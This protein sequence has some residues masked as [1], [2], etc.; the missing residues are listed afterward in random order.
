MCGFASN[1]AG[2]R[3]IIREYASYAAKAR[4]GKAKEG[5]LGAAQHYLRQAQRRGWL[6]D[7]DPITCA[8]KPRA[9]PVHRKGMEVVRE[10]I[11]EAEKLPP[12]PVKREKV[13]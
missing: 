8:Q 4:S 1:E 5:Y 7:Y 11:R 3:S 2:Y 6:L 10:A 9:A 12:A 13:N